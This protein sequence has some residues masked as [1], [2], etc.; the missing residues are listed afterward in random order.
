MRVS[1][2]AAA[3]FCLSLPALAGPEQDNVAAQACS[4]ACEGATVAA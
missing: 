3:A 1:A 2:L 4:R